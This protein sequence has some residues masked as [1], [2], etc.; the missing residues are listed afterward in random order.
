M[1][2]PNSEKAED[3]LEDYYQL[4][5]VPMKKLESNETRKNI[6]ISEYLHVTNCNKV[7][8]PTSFATLTAF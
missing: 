4:N 2:Y 1:S 7:P 8:R 3:S 5:A 6:E